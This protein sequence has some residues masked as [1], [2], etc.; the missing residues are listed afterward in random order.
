MKKS[1]SGE[2]HWLNLRYTERQCPGMN[3]ILASIPGQ[4]SALVRGIVYQW[5]LEHQEAGTLIPATLAVLNGPGVKGKRGLRRSGAKKASIPASPAHTM[6]HATPHLEKV[7]QAPLPAAAT[8]AH[9]P[10]LPPV[11]AAS[12]AAVPPPP[13]ISPA[14]VPQAFGQRD[15]APSSGTA[16]DALFDMFDD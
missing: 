8:D 7:E 5:C 1:E 4:Q 3:D 13:D 2:V 9:R 16:A 14:A 6:P 12:P 15:L 11:Q 10:E